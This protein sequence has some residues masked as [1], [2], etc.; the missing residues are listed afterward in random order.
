MEMDDDGCFHLYQTM[1]GWYYLPFP[2]KPATS[3]WWKMDNGSRPK[4]MG[5]DMNIHVIIRETEGGIDVEIETSGV[6]GAP[7]R[8]ELAFFGIDRISNPHMTRPVRGDEVLV[9]NDSY[10]KVHNGVNSMEVGPA[11][12]TH[13]FT[14]GKEDSETRTPGA[15]TVYFTDYTEFHH[16]ISIRP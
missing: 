9:L 12:G 6:E 3:D 16:T 8:V 4:K 13:H 5:P 14:E 11:F 2:Q 1:R 15:A 7:W 10:F